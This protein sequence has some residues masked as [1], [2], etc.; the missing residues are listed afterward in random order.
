[1]EARGLRTAQMVGQ[2]SLELRVD[3]KEKGSGV[4]AHSALNEAESKI[5][6]SV[7]SA[8]ATQSGSRSAGAG[9]RL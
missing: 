6:V 9:V 7:K 8:W 3:K 5:S 1:M 4:L 2:A